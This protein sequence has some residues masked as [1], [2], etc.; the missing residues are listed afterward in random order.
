MDKQIA[1]FDQKKDREKIKYSAVFCFEFLVIK[2]LDPEPDPYPDS[3]EMLDP[4]PYP[5]PDS[6]NTDPQ[7]WAVSCIYLFWCRP[8]KWASPRGEF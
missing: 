8:R 1:I 4:D 5:D 7:H 6:M 2:T 3:L